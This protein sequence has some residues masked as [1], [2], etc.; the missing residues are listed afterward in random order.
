[1]VP[2]T[3]Q[4][5]FH[6]LF[7]DIFLFPENIHTSWHSR[8]NAGMGGMRLDRLYRISSSKDDAKERIACVMHIL[9]HV[10]ASGVVQGSITLA[11]YFVGFLFLRIQSDSYGVS[12]KESDEFF[13]L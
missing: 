3:H 6:Q 10:K 13:P 2:L 7:I 11:S 12:Q 4:K 1:M 5:G 8:Q 9:S